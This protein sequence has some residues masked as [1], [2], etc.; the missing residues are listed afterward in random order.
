MKAAH[1]CHGSTINYYKSCAE[2]NG[3]LGGGRAIDVT[4]VV[5]S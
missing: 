1:W 2:L 4:W 3:V 5:L